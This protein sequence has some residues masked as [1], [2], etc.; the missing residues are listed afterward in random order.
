VDHLHPVHHAVL[1]QPQSPSWRVQVSPA[2]DLAS[3]A[4]NASPRTASSA[5]IPAAR[6]GS[7]AAGRGVAW[8]GVCTVPDARRIWP[9]RR[10][11]TTVCPASIGG[12]LAWFVRGPDHHITTYL[13]Y[14][15]PSVEACDRDD[16][17]SP[18]LASWVGVTRSKPG[19]M[20]DGCL[21]VGVDPFWGP[22][23]LTAPGIH[24]TAGSPS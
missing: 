14:L 16:T 11:D 24:S 10:Y 18:L 20:P 23:V 8:C 2:G 7:S 21:K 12:P 19:S 17:R 4:R 3:Y 6:L 22:P 13:A 5:F 15:R 9:L 1:D